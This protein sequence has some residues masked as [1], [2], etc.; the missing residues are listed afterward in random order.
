MFWP[1]NR[2]PCIPTMGGQGRLA[3]PAVHPVPMC[4]GLLMPSE[5]GSA[6]ACVCKHLGL[7]WT[8]GPETGDH[9][10]GAAAGLLTNCPLIASGFFFF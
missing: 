6:Q 2:P 8:D 1:V 5:G 10:T 9:R 4:G 3:D 7:L